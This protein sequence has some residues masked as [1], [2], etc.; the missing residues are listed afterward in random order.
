MFDDL[1]ARLNSIAEWLRWSPLYGDGT[2]L[3]RLVTIGADPADPASRTDRRSRR[4]F[5]TSDP[6]AR[7]RRPRP[8]SWRSAVE[9][10][11]YVVG[12]LV[13][14]CGW[15]P[16]TSDVMLMCGESLHHIGP[17]PVSPT[18]EVRTPG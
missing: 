12:R 1:H 6:V 14:R 10:V 11:R 17:S 9:V 8:T 3:H 15:S 16:V 4:G 18:G 5:S 13:A 2:G 7:G